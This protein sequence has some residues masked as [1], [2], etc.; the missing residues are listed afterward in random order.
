MAVKIPKST[1][2]QSLSM[3][4]LIDVVFLLLIFF[5]VATRFAEEERSM[6]V[7]LPTASESKPITMKPKDIE[8]NID[9]EGQYFLGGGQSLTLEQMELALGRLAVNNPLTQTVVIRADRSCSWD[10]VAQAM[11]AC[12]RAGLQDVKTSIS[13]Q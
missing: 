1:V 2:L 5:L 3:T 9:Q 7:N 4:P 10:R 8:L 11:N 6:E 12:H 13:G